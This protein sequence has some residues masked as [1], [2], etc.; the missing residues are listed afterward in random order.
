MVKL[1]VRL[2]DDVVERLRDRSRSARQ[3]VNKVLLETLW[4][5]LGE[6]LPENEGWRSFGELVERPASQRFDAKQWRALV[7]KAGSAERR[8]ELSAGLLEA[9]DQTRED[10]I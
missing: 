10:R 3:S 6:E 2:P 1:T 8:R 4:R 7:R 5:G 9:L